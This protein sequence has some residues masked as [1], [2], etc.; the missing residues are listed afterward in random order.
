MLV[1]HLVLVTVNIGNV[2]VMLV[3]HLV[4]VITVHR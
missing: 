3:D 4:L 1:D 2:G